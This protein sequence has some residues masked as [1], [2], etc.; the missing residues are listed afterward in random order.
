MI[1]TDISIIGA[2]Q[3]ILRGTQQEENGM[4]PQH[5]IKNKSTIQLKYL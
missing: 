5:R 3:I 1:Q 4:D 2:L